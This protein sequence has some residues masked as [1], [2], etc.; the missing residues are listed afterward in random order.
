[1]H[2][3]LSNPT[4][5]SGL[6]KVTIEEPRKKVKEPEPEPEPV[7]EVDEAKIIEARRKRREAIKAKYRLQQMHND[8]TPATPATPGTPASPTSPRQDETTLSEP[9]PAVNPAVR[10]I[11]ETDSAPQS[12]DIESREESPSTFDFG[13]EPAEKKVEDGEPSAADYDPV[14][15]M[16]EDQRRNEQRLHDQEVSAADF[17]ERDSNNDMLIPETKK[18]TED[19]DDDFDM[20]AEGDDDDMFAEK[21]NKLDKPQNKVGKVVNANSIAQGN[22]I[23]V[24]LLDNSDDPEGYYRVLLGELLDD[25]Y[26]VQA[27][28]GKGSFASVI[29]CFDN[30]TNSLKAIKMIR[31]NET[32]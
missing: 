7:E 15:D 25:R 27:N 4:P 32:L 13:K 19:D 5:P 1:L 28:L 2:S 12:P 16:E 3:D 17:E 6:K 11:Q 29:R 23:K 18:E 30:K 26:Q 8:S 31:N 10:A 24:N 21:P 9:K 14:R 22:T 20:F